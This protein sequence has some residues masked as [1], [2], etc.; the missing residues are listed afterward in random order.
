MTFRQVSLCLVL[1]GFLF[2][3]G[4]S[5]E[6]P[7]E[8][9]K[10]QPKQQ[11]APAE[12]PAPTF[13]LAASYAGTWKRNDGATFTVEDDGTTISGTLAEDP[14]ARWE[15][16]T[17]TLT[18]SDQ[19]L[20]GTSTFKTAEGGHSAELG[21]E[22]R[23]DADEN[24]RG[25]IQTAWVDPDSGELLVFADDPEWAQ[26]TFAVE[27]P[28]PESSGPVAAVP[29]DETPTDETPTD[30]TPTDETPTDETPAEPA[31][32]HAALDAAEAEQASL[33]MTALNEEETRLSGELDAAKE[34]YEARKAE[35]AAREEA[36]R[37][38]AEEAARLKAE[39]EARLK[40]EEEARLKAEEE[41]RLKAE[42]E[43]RLKAEEEA[44]LKAEAETPT[45]ETPTDETPTETPTD[46]TPTDETPTET[47]MDETP[48]DETPTETTDET[49]TDETPTDE[50]PTDETPT[51]ETPTDETPAETD[52]ARL[53]R[54]GLEREAAEESGAS[55]AP[56]RSAEQ[57]M[58]LRKTP[59]GFAQLIYDAVAYGDAALFKECWI[60][61]SDATTLLGKK[62]GKTW[63]KRANRELLK[64]WKTLRR[65]HPSLRKGKLESVVAPV[66]DVEF[67][68]KQL[69]R[70]K[71]GAVK[72]VVEGR[73]GELPLA[74]LFQLEDGSWKAFALVKA[75]KKEE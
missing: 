16:L 39:E 66:V 64:S 71:G 41:A 45:D 10:E 48:T 35:R 18:R 68:G 62:V 51:D 56:E 9:P 57:I 44:R 50:T 36:R 22:L 73:N 30:E 40:A 60:S 8:Q 74:A 2:G 72:Y 67:S 46:E 17:F 59:E 52:E 31:V 33:A 58:E 25:R 13:D 43:A 49:P 63:Y 27:R 70:V 29:T 21:M 26:H 3:C 38:A 1:A 75:K 65:M 19:R 55:K 34:A 6:G 42:E 54:E 20:R 12:Q 32:D 11:E 37:K 5:D 28:A 23:A 69:K 24:L 4:S 7:K 61:K 15:S 47:P 14:E 53:E